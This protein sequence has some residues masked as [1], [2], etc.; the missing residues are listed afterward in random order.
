MHSI[1]GLD[2]TKYKGTWKNG[3]NKI[4]IKSVNGSKI[5][6]YMYTKYAFGGRFADATTTGTIK[7]YSV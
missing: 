6:V 4:V 1:W 3:N 7:N 2:Y 5:K